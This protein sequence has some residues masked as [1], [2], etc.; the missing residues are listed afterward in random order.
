MTPQP[1]RRFLYL[2]SAICSMKFLSMVGAPG[3]PYQLDVLHPAVLFNRIRNDRMALIM[4]TR[5]HAS[6][7]KTVPFTFQLQRA[8]LYVLLLFLRG[9]R[10]L[11]R[12]KAKYSKHGHEKHYCETEKHPSL[13]HRHAEKVPQSTE[14]QDDMEQSSRIKIPPCRK[15]LPFSG[16]TDRP[17]RPC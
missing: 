11:V 7:R 9:H 6:N 4:L 5:R 1:G 15:S 10:L 13:D 2:F 14:T 17:K 8:P 16:S 3:A 12:C